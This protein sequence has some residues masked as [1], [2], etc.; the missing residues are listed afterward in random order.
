MK[1]HYPV[2]VI[3]AAASMIANAVA[4]VAQYRSVV[5]AEP[6][7]LSFYPFDGDTAPTAIDR[8][9]SLQNGTL[10]GAT[11]SAAAGTLGAQS[12]QGARVALGSVT[13]YEFRDGSG[14]VEMFLYQT[15]TA[16]FN[17]CF[18]AGR[19]D[20]QNPAVRYSMHA[21]ANGSQLWIWNGATAQSVATPVSMLN[22]LVHVAYVYDAG[23]LTVYFNGA[24]L[25]TWSSPLGSGTGRS[26]QIGASGPANQEAW[27][28]RIDEVAIYSDAL[29]AS[30]IAAHYNA[31]LFQSNSLLHETFTGIAGSSVGDLTTAAAYPDSP[32]ASTL[33]TNGF[34]LSTNAA[35]NFGRRVSG[36]VVPPQSGNYTFWISSADAS[37]LWL[38]TNDNPTTRTRI[39]SVNGATA[40]QQWNAEPNQ[41]S[42]VVLLNAGQRYY[43]EALHKAGAGTDHLA[44]R[45]QL[46][47]ATIEAPIPVTRLQPFGFEA[48][49]L[50]VQPTNLTVIEPGAATFSV[51]VFRSAGVS[52]QWQ[53]DGTNIPGA[54]AS[55]YTLPTT[56]V[57]DASPFRCVVVNAFGTNVSAEATLTVRP[58]EYPPLV[59]SITT[60]GENVI[61]IT[62][63]EPIAFHPALTNAANYGVNNGV[64]VLR[65]GFGLTPSVI[66]LITS[67]LAAGTSYVVT[68][69]N[70]RD[71]YGNALPPGT[72]VNVGA[73]GYTPLPIGFIKPRFGA[74]GP[75]TR[76]G[77]F[78]ISEI[79]YH[80]TNR[81]DGRNLEFVELYNSQ[82]WPE[83][84]GGYRLSGEIDFAIPS[85]TTIPA[86][87]YLVIASSPADVA[88]VYGITNVIGG[89]T[90]RLNNAGGLLRLRDVS[91]GV[92]FEVEYDTQP[93]WPA[94]ADGAGHSLVLARPSYGMNDPRSWDS[95]VELGGSPGSINLSALSPSTVLI[96]EFLANGDATP[97]FVELFNYS[98]QTVNLAG[99]TLSDDAG[100]NKF[101][102]APG[103]TLAPLGFVVLDESQLG[104]SLSSGG[105]TIWLRNSLGRVID[106]IRFDGQQRGVSTGRTPDG[107]PVLSRLRTPTPG[108]ANAT[109]LSADVVLNEIMYNP[110][111]GNDADEFVELKNR[112]TGPVNVGG[113]RLRGGVSH[114]IAAGTIIPAGG[115]LVIASDRENLMAKDPNLT[116]ANTVG[117]FNGQLA[118]SGEA[119]RLEAAEVTVT[120]NGATLVTNTS[121]YTVSEVSYGTGG[122]WGRWSDGGGSS[123]ELVDA[124]SDTRL[125]ANWVDSDESAKSGWKTIEFTGPLDNGQGTA[126]RLQILSQGV[127][128]FLVDDVEL[129]LVGNPANRVGN[130]DFAS[131]ELGW[132]K[133]GS[134]STSSIE[135][136]GGVNGSPA[137]RVRA[138]SR[139]DTSANRIQT[140]LTSSLS[141]GQN[142]TLRAKVRWLKGH[143]EILLR[144][145]G[146]W[147]EAPGNMLTTTAFGTPGAQNSATVVVASRGPAIS[148]V[149]HQPVLP[150]AGQPVTVYARIDDPD[151]I[152]SAALRYR[153]DPSSATATVSMGYHGAGWF[154]AQIPTQGD[155]TLVAFHI[156]AVDGTGVTSR[157]PNGPPL[158]EALVRWGET[159]IGGALGSYRFWM[160]QATRTR[161]ETRERNSNEPL[162]VTFIYG[163]TRV[164]Y[165]ADAQYSGSPFHTPA[166]S[167]PLGG[168]CDYTLGFPDDDRLLGETGMILA[169]PG[170]FGD[171]L[172]FQRE[173]MLWWMARQMGGPALHRRFVRLH[174]NGTRRQTIFEDVQQ[175]NSEVLREYF[176]GDDDGDLFKAQDWIEF[177]DD[178]ATFLGGL[179]RAVL[180][181][182]T[183]ANNVLPPKRY[184]WMWAPRA[185]TGPVNDF[186][187]FM[188]LVETL[189]LTD[190]ATYTAQVEGL[191]DVESW[192]RA[193]AVQRIVGNWDSWG[194]SYGKNMYAYKPRNGRWAMVPWD[195]DF[196]YGTLGLAGGNPASDPPTS[197]LFS[198]TSSFDGGSPGDP[199]ATTFRNNAQ[200]RRAYARALLDAANGPMT[201][202]VVQA[203]LTMILTALQAEGFTPASP[204][205]IRTYISGRRAYILN[206]LA[207]LLNAPLAVTLNG[208]AD[209][210]TSS[211]VIRVTGTAPASIKTIVVNGAAYPVTWTTATNWSLLLPLAPGA[212]A[213]TVSGYD[214]RG[215][216][217]SNLT[218]TITITSTA[219][220]VSPVGSV[221]INEIL[222][223]PAVADT[224]FVELLNTSTNTFD[225]TGWRL[226]GVDFEFP[227]GSVITNRQ[228]LVI[229]ADRFAFGN[230]FG[231]G[232]VVAG[233]FDARLDNDGEVLSLLKPT[234]TNT[235]PLVV[236]RVRYEAVT[237]WPTNANGAGPSLQLTDA[238]ADNARVSNWSDGSGWRFFSLTTNINSSRLSVLFDNLGGDV[239]L[240]DLS[241][242]PGGVAGVGVNSIVNGDFESPLLPSW[243]ATGVATNSHVTNG[244]ARSGASSLHYVQVPG[245]AGLT[246]FYQDVSPPVVTNTQYTLSGWYLPGNNTNLTIR[247]STVFQIKPNLRPAGPTPGAANLGAGIVAGYPALW[248][249]EALPQNSSGATDAAG[250]RDPWIE[251]HNVGDAPVSLDG[252]ILSDDFVNLAQWTFPSG[253]SIAPGGFLVVWCD[254]EPGESSPTELHT[255]FRLSSVSGSIALSRNV[256]GSPQI[257][258][259]LNYAGL[260]ANDSYGSVPDGQP[261][262]RG[263]MFHPTP[264]AANDGRSAP[265]VVFI[266]EWMAANTSA[267]GFADPAD[268]NYEDWFELYNPGPNAVDLGGHFLTDNLAEKFQFEVPDN[269]H[270]IIPPGGH[271]LVWADNETGQNST[272]RAD[273]HVSFSLRA[274]GEAIGLFA[275]DGTQI[276]AV[277]FA[278]QLD[279]VSMGRQPDGSANIIALPIASPRGSNGGG[280]VPAPAISGVAI[281]NGNQVR[282]SVSTVAGK[283][284]QVEFKDNWNTAAWQPLGGPRIATGGSFEVSDSQLN[285][286]QRFYRI[287]VQ[288]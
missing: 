200:F 225:L 178:G 223:N 80:P 227:P 191:V 144:L 112:S 205:G 278:N 277:T 174:V 113:W 1:S 161:W 156:E 136:A 22:N 185:V 102:F 39:A 202:A 285:G 8:K 116:T 75:A 74:I 118:N 108:G 230:R 60:L 201:D 207:S 130:P 53:R 31:Y 139:G 150:A 35:D 284:Y 163:D 68:L 233:D 5:Q 209:F 119:L 249:N 245:A 203:R 138:S 54:T 153:I 110:I 11:F 276:D 131:G 265:I 282:F 85:G 228:L 71:L 146:S 192:S 196:S 145:R 36:F 212:N 206:Q 240:D 92:V 165:N 218:D 57:S 257:L 29:S 180:G 241:L 189:N 255:S 127:G 17:P 73:S 107:S 258:D 239:Y 96:N 82:P 134:H 19:D 48:P 154:S 88:S 235:P 169:G 32:S 211:S 253:L 125:A 77:P 133:Q 288:P 26:F 160:T 44:V 64:T 6:S 103:T 204:D 244:V 243:I 199:V 56:T 34:V 140:S 42:A 72:V 171:D 159:S 52:Y 232:A 120:T 25:T 208:G 151:G 2:V 219:D 84:L 250:D 173:Q 273:L 231:A 195:M 193:L 220:A 280:I 181:R 50:T 254:G 126:D 210:S 43:I 247:A 90:N 99:Y 7:L 76:R 20:S 186:T 93:P 98:T 266:N 65:A 12:V 62:F 49:V 30:A 194:W 18:F 79:M 198:N 4:D 89:F 91:D 263:A 260:R 152:P 16:A 24:V 197:D 123:L 147:L 216:L 33:L 287:I 23:S 248:L 40:P 256:G 164:I 264:G 63:D 59:Q 274:A 236:D 271:L 121:Y 270:Y 66:F 162:G 168:A 166:F 104:F 128:E 283:S 213:L 262:Y 67:P 58:D 268:G 135:T 115:F 61:T 187:N 149:T 13:D 97:D 69:N 129:L 252:M 105:E 45:W 281:V 142:A 242:V 279:N 214:Q 3:V 100:T 41:Q 28:G 94:A 221:V 47:D 170:T 70:I 148:D 132:L 261:F 46:P 184:R 157:H 95:S 251:L 21:G 275:A 238:T 51:G 37:E 234:G 124:N 224:A 190:A 101:T 9:A 177:G 272:N 143:P 109:R 286:Q 222:Y 106:A 167:S 14:T 86:Q 183:T 81:V 10:T 38:G 155:G 229:A 114:T 111:S 226:D 237:P 259:Y 267:S 137:F 141:S 15:S 269:G 182:F 87:G 246:A 117:N 176:P 158:D 217:L 179:Q 172:T 175:P 55:S 27:P 188:T 215:N 122:R 78:V 83:D